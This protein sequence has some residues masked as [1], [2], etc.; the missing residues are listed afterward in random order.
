MR[1]L[2]LF[3]AGKDSMVAACRLVIQGQ[4]VG[5]IAMNNGALAAPEHI[6]WAYQRLARVFGTQAI[7]Y[8]GVYNTRGTIMEFHKWYHD[9]TLTGLKE[10]LGDCTPSQIQC[11]HCQTAMWAAAI[12]YAR[13]HNYQSVA[14]GYLENDAFC[15]GSDLYVKDIRAVA[16]QFGIEVQLPC[17]DQTGTRDWQEQRDLEMEWAGLIPKVLEPKCLLGMPAPCINPGMKQQLKD[18]YDAHIQ[19]RFVK[20]IGLLTEIFGTL[21][22][23]KVGA[24]EGFPENPFAKGEW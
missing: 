10:T 7:T 12:A 16:E 23:D 19:Q 5:L 24:I 20:E 18:Y 17:W 13:V 9:Q 3:S 2:L 4:Q 22:L 1:T 15:T 14:A 11:F 8:E 21:K 6:D